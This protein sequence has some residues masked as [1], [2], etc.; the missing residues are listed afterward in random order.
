MVIAHCGHATRQN[1]KYDNRHNMRKRIHFSAGNQLAGSLAFY[2]QILSFRPRALTHC[3][4]RLRRH[5]ITGVTTKSQT[6]WIVSVLSCFQGGVKKD[7]LLPSI[8]H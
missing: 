7:E 1:G 3:S 8:A 2:H 5:K 4:I 6:A